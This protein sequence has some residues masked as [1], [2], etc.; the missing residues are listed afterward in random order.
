MNSSEIKK[1]VGRFRSEF[2]IREVTAEALEDVFQR[3]GFTVVDFNPILNDPD[4]TTVIESLGLTDMI[5]HS[6]GFLYTDSNYRLVF[7]N[8]ISRLHVVTTVFKNH[9]SSC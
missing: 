2:D 9:C 6:D 4:V 8:L 1:L 5:R 3:Q 7:I